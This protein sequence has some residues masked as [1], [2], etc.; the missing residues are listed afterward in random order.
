[1]NERGRLKRVTGGFAGHAG[2]GKIPQFV[3]NDRQQI[4]QPIAFT[5]IDRLQ[6]QRHFAHIQC[7]LRESIPV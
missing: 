5:T 4:I 1:M 3:V 7:K 6:N 2:C